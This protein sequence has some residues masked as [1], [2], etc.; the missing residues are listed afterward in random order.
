[1]Y[2]NKKKVMISQP[3]F[4]ARQTGRQ[5]TLQDVK[6]CDDWKIRLRRDDKIHT[7]PDRFDSQ[8][9]ERAPKEGKTI[10]QIFFE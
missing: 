6:I 7:R 4:N 3:P 8:P 9:T 10:F 1:M 2:V 5:Q